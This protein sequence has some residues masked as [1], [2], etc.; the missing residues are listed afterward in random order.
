MLAI[1]I[2]L[3][4]SET[5]QPTPA[6][7]SEPNFTPTVEPSSAPS[8]QP[9]GES[10]VPVL[11]AGSTTITVRDGTTA[12]YIIGEQLARLSVPSDAL[13]E[14]SD[15]AGTIVFNEDGSVLSEAS[16]L[17][18]GVDDLTSD[19]FRRDNYLRRNSI[20]SSRFPDVRF[21]VNGTEGLTWPLPTEGTASFTLLG[22]M[23]IRDATRPVTLNVD[24]EF[25][26]DSIIANAS[27]VITFDQFDLSKPRLA[28]IL[29]VEDEIRLELDIQASIQTGS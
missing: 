27:T 16:A 24:A 25:A 23:T 11:D 22:D 20:Q 5:E 19:E 17:I 3:G 28:F 18:V 4:C 2:V 12:R 1:L 9:P 26:G 8:N 15:V 6:P 21:V 29:S 10:A 7:N 14:T 13:G